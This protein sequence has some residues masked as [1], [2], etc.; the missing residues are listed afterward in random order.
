MTYQLQADWDAYSAIARVT[1]KAYL[2]I[3]V[4]TETNKLDDPT[5]S[6]LTKSDYFILADSE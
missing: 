1:I 4:A 3:V 2:I 5:Q 6:F